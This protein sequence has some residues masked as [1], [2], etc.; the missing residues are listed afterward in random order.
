[1]SRIYGKG[2]QPSNL[3]NQ[4]YGPHKFN[5][6]FYAQIGRII[7]I[8]YDRYRMKVE[9]MNGGGSPDWFPISFPYIGPAGQMGAMPEIGAFA[10]CTYIKESETG[11]GS[12]LSAAAFLPVSLQGAL[13]HNSVKILPDSLPTEDDNLLFLKFRKLIKG[14]MIMSSMY[15]GEVF[16]NKDVEIKDGLHDSILL[17]SS[18]QSII[19]TSLNHFVFANGVAINA[20]PIIR[21]KMQGLFD[22]KGNRNPDM[23]ARELSLPDGRDNI[24]IVPNGKNIQEGSLFYSEYRID[25]DEITDASLDVNDI[26]QQSVLSNRDPIVSM[27]MGNYVGNDDISNNLGKVLRPQ[28]FTSA[29]D[30]EGYFNMV[31]CQQNKG[32]DEVTKLGMAFAVHL[33]KTNGFMGFDK[34]GHFYLNMGSSSSANPTGAGRSMS[35][36]GQGNLKEVWGSSADT[37]NSWDL[38]TKGGISWDIGKHNGKKNSRSIDIRTSSGIHLEA[39]GNDVLSSPEPIYPGSNTRV[40][41]YGY[42]ATITGN[43]KVEVSGSETL[44]VSGESSLVVNGLRYEEIRGSASY[45][46]QAD[47][48]E[49]CLGVYTQVVVKEMQGRFGKRKETVS[50]GQE[51]TVLTGDIKETIQT[52]GNKKTWLTKGNIEETIVAGDRKVNIIAGNYKVSVGAGGVDIKAIGS[53]KLTGLKGVTIQGLKTDIKSATVSLGALPVKGGVVTGL[54]GVPS[55]LCYVTGIPPKGSVTVKASI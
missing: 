3:F 8:D 25:V 6:Y 2:E 12:P 10:I 21:N 52:F 36:L 35:I 46:Y 18:D 31:E 22:S 17:R 41:G 54:P 9:W 29:S 44:Q 32:I 48:S 42:R 19:M 23:L 20:G 16:V 27:I 4:Q 14:D 49:N 45:S 24:Y 26:N 28:L 7:D 30:L 53:A 43:K 38:S 33:L 11:K 5:R 55:T 37:G 13:E 47:K 51:L 15:G 39:Q 40:S 50:L 1:M 34:E